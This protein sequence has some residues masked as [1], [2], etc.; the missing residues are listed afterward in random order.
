MISIKTF[1]LSASVKNQHLFVKD[2]ELREKRLQC[3]S[4]HEKS[5]THR[6]ST[7]KKAAMSSSTPKA[8]RYVAQSTLLYP[9]SCMT[10]F[11]F[12]WAQ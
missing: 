9:I 4:E 8:A 1:C 6:E 5:I 12:S 7:M 10:G 2:L 3:F 11:T